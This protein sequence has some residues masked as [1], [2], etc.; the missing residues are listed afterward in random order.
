MFEAPF[1]HSEQ[2]GLLI[3]SFILQKNWLP[4]SPPT[5]FDDEHNA[6]TN[7]YSLAQPFSQ[8]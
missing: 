7:R 2:T 3:V 8:L 5:L 4:L 6:S 1:A